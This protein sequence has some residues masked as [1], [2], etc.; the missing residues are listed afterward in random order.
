MA[1]SSCGNKQN[2]APKT[3]KISKVTLKPNQIRIV[4]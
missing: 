1:C 4:K 2:V 3:V